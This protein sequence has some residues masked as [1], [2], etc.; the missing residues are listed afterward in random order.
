M[1]NIFNLILAGSTLILCLLLACAAH[2]SGMRSSANQ[3][4]RTAGEAKFDPLRYP[5]DDDVITTD[6]PAAIDSQD[7]TGSIKLP[8]ENTSNSKKAVPIFA[9]QVFASKSSAEAR[10][11]KLAKAS[12]FAE[13]MRVD[14]QAPYY[15]VIVGRSEGLDDA[16]ILLKKVQ[17]QGFP[18]AW[19]VRLRQ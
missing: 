7:E 5:G 8:P 15:R 13:E 4:K 2:N 1:R 10:D 14:Y 17:N 12:L 16:E 18:E 11:F 9:V 6:V 3:D 19:L